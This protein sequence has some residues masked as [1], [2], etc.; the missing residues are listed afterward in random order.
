MMIKNLNLLSL[1]IIFLLF[2]GC[3]YLSNIPLDSNQNAK[4]DKK[5]IGTW[6]NPDEQNDSLT[7]LNIYQFNEREHL[8]MI[9]E[10]NEIALYGAHVT[11]LDGHKFLNV[12]R[13]ESEPQEKLEYAFVKYQVH[14]D[15]LFLQI[16]EDQI[17]KEQFNNSKKLRKFISENLKNDKLFGEKESLI[18]QRE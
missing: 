6:G 4:I 9:E 13:L 1:L 12:H 5:L 2:V 17:I 16:I 8:I 10:E 18:R 14:N 3:P 11:L 7:A 15:T